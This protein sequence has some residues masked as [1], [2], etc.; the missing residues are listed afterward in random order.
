MTIPA[1]LRSFV[2]DGIQTGL[3]HQ[4]IAKLSP[5]QRQLFESTDFH[6]GGPNLY[7]KR[8]PVLEPG[9]G[10][11]ISTSDFETTQLQRKRIR[12]TLAS[13]VHNH[14]KGVKAKYNNLLPT[15]SFQGGEVY[16]LILEEE[17]RL[18]DCK[19]LAEAILDGR[20]AD[21]VEAS[22]ELSELFQKDL[23][24]EDAFEA[25][26]LYLF[27]Q[28]EV[29]SQDAMD[30]LED[31]D[32]PNYITLLGEGDSLIKISL[33]SLNS[34]FGGRG[35]TPPRDSYQLV[36]VTK[37]DNETEGA[38]EAN[39]RKNSCGTL[40]RDIYR[41]E[42]PD[43]REHY[44]DVAY[45]K[46]SKSLYSQDKQWN[47]R[48][49]Q[50]QHDI[51]IENNVRPVVAGRPETR[52]IRSTDTYHTSVDGEEYYAKVDMFDAPNIESW[53]N[54]S[55]F[56][57]V[58]SALA[59]VLQ[60]Q[61]EDGLLTPETEERVIVRPE[62]KP[63]GHVTE[64][65]I[66]KLTNRYEWIWNRRKLT[67]TKDLNFTKAQWSRIFDAYKDRREQLKQEKRNKN[68]RE[69]VTLD[70]PGFTFKKEA[71]AFIKENLNQLSYGQYQQLV[72]I[73]KEMEE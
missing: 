3:A 49:G 33:S 23:E 67:A 32:N 19:K 31:I 54:A 16:D 6:F 5:L 68:K 17:E 1:N 43:Y 53:V 71:L 36:R 57:K 4:N 14:S 20:R 58:H 73:V 13:M 18:R 39:R 48:W 40:I 41:L 27:A 59:Q 63:D 9:E 15:E 24:Y 10:V 60:G 30:H 70:I 2:E 47:A 62:V 26:T 37:F 29:E 52:F 69:V 34:Q 46:N 50:E 72:D 55:T 21:I 66:R 51:Y 45:S 64:D 42:A 35:Y 38:I 61:Y 25:V 7:K 11:D 12:E 44:R 8:D 28:E 65:K 22:Q 56:I